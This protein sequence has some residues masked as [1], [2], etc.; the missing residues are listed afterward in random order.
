MHCGWVFRIEFSYTDRA[1]H[2]FVRIGSFLKFSILCKFAFVFM[3][4]F[5][6][7][8]FI[9]VLNVKGENS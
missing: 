7:F 2:N 9:F 8:A 3:F 4:G 5:T 6:I 1:R